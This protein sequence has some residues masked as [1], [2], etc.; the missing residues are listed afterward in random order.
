LLDERPEWNALRGLSFDGR[1]TRRPTTDGVPA[2]P[3]Q[4]CC[5]DGSTTKETRRSH[6]QPTVE[7][8]E[9]IVHEA[10]EIQNAQ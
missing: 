10:L 7:T 9:Q 8:A 6:V 5:D 4:R 2:D 3:I 1:D